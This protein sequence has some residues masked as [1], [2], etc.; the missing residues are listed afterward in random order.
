MSSVSVDL[1]LRTIDDF[2]RPPE[3]DP[4]AD[5]F[6]KYSLTSGIDYVIN[7]VGDKPRVSHVDV[8]I[9]M[10]RDA[11]SAGLAE[12][13][14]AG[15]DRYCDA[16]LRIVHEEAREDRSRGWLM[17]AFAVF[18]VFVLVWVA[19]QFSGSGQTLLGVASE[20]LSIAAWVMLWHPLEELVFNRWDHRL[21]QRALRTVRDRSKVRIE[22]LVSEAE[23]QV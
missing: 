20:G 10:P 21:D 17:M 18:A 11:I 3:V 1:R 23:T 9:R 16:R 14:K 22:P 4:M 2:F 8:L 6:Q 7:E 5:W 19:R 13:V 12:R 15:I